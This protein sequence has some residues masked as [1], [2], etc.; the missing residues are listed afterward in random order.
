MSHRLGSRL[1]KV[2]AVA[3]M[4]DGKKG[5]LL[6]FSCCTVFAILLCQRAKYGGD[7]SMFALS[8]SLMLSQRVNRGCEYQEMLLVFS[9][10]SL[11]KMMAR[12]QVVF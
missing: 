10:R 9:L 5:A 8:P 3:I 4:V 6:L 2:A 12:H 7:E 11:D 1:L